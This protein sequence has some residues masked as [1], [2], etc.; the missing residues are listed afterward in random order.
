MARPFF[1]EPVKKADDAVALVPY[2]PSEKTEKAVKETEAGLGIR[3]M[4][5]YFL[6]WP[7]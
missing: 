6:D 3:T 2:E 5:G 1:S 7:F 4:R